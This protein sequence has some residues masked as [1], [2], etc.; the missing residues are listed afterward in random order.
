M[1]TPAR[2]HTA[3]RAHARGIHPDEAGT[4]LLISHGTLL[5]RRDFRD[6]FIHQNTRTGDRT[7]LA[8]IDWSA[9]TTAANNG[10]LPC[11]AGER[12]ILQIAASLAHGIPVDLRDALTGLDHH[13][14]HLVTTAILHAA[15]ETTH[16]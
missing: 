6:R 4:E 11:S 13:N 14:I 9:A 3:L 1:N 10:R 2:L 7:T 15:G 16:P 5:A 8:S 12:H